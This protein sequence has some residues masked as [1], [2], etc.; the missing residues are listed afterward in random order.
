MRYLILA[1]FLLFNRAYAAEIVKV[2]WPFGVSSPFVSMQ[3]I[4]TVANKTQD[5]FEFVMEVKPGAGGDIAASYALQNNSLLL[6]SSGFIINPLIRKQSKDFLNSFT[7]AFLLVYDEPMVLVSK[8]FTTYEDFLKADNPTIGTSGA[9]FTEIAARAFL[10]GKGVVV[11]FKNV[12]E[13]TSAN[14]GKHIDASIDFYSNVKLLHD[15][16][17]INVLAQTGKKIKLNSGLERLTSHY[18]VY[19]PNSFDPE[20]LKKINQL[21]KNIIMSDYAQEPFQ[22]TGGKFKSLNLKE[23]RVFFDDQ[24]LFWKTTVEGMNITPK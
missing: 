9:G 20:K 24:K 18:M 23:T 11:P 10:N 14:I 15:A 19:A 6:T 2:V 12:N 16:G 1:F 17:K 4:A 5:E 13:A 3:R 8:K 21:F 22:Y 7:P